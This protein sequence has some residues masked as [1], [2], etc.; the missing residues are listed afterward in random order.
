MLKDLELFHDHSISGIAG[1]S[2][3]EAVRP[4]LLCYGFVECPIWLCS[5]GKVIP[6]QPHRTYYNQKSGYRLSQYHKNSAYTSG[7]G[8]VKV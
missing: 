6:E 2:G 7:L 8:R 4:G 5:L 3:V 1:L